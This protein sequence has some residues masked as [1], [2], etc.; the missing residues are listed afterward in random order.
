[1]AGEGLVGGRD[2]A[3][4]GR[5]AVRRPGGAWSSRPGRRPPGSGTRRP[6]ASVAWELAEVDAVDGQ[7]AVL[8]GRCTRGTALERRVLRGLG[9]GCGAISTSILA[10]SSAWRRLCSTRVRATKVERW[11]KK[12]RMCRQAVSRRRLVEPGRVEGEVAVGVPGGLRARSLGERPGP[13]RTACTSSMVEVA[14]C[15]QGAGQG[16]GDGLVPRRRGSA[17]RPDRVRM[18]RSTS[19]AASLCRSFS[20]S[21]RFS[22]RKETRAEIRTGLSTSPAPGPSSHEELLDERRDGAGRQARADGCGI[23]VPFPPVVVAGLAGQRTGRA[24]TLVPKR[25]PKVPGD[26]RRLTTR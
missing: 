11:V 13:S 1:M 19:S 4:G 12:C 7:R 18:A 22:P 6:A 10:I 9:A 20:V 26:D 23:H 24:G 21:V 14:Q 5:A 17:A 2:A 25:T 15:V 16:V 8:L 3:A